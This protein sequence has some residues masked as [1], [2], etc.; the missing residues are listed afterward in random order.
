MS[1]KCAVLS[2]IVISYKHAYRN[3]LCQMDFNDNHDQ[4]FL[5]S[6]YESINK[7]E[8]DCM[9]KTVKFCEK[10]ISESEN[11]AKSLD[12]QL[13]QKLNDANYKAVTDRIKHHRDDTR[14]ILKQRK[15]KKLNS[16]RF[17]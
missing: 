10:T 16:L 1:T 4:E 7:C 13:K 17:G 11:Q 8:V 12:N 3:N 2:P 5:Q 14:R 6:I 15:S 9:Q